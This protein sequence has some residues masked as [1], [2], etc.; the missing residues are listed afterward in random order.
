MGSSTSSALPPSKSELDSCCDVCGKPHAVLLCATCVTSRYCSKECQGKD[1]PQHKI[2]CKET[3]K[4]KEQEL[5]A[6]MEE[7]KKLA[8][9]EERAAAITAVRNPPC[10]MCGGVSFET[11]SGC[12]FIHYCD[13]DLPCK[14]G[15]CGS[16]EEAC[17]A[18]A[19]VGSRR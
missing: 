8:E 12:G 3:K 19:D 15:V 10:G 9:E 14:P 1:W 2:P 17:R 13:R 5:L 7:K 4:K 16:E 6:A 11:C 18:R